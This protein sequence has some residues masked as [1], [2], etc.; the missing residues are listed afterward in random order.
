MD[1]AVLVRFVGHGRA[2]ESKSCNPAIM[3][4]IHD[5]CH[6]AASFTEHTLLI[7]YLCWK[8]TVGK[9]EQFASRIDECEEMSTSNRKYR[10]PN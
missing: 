10:Q 8:V 6:L 4:I 1:N 7:S 5:C 2:L 3:P 9:G